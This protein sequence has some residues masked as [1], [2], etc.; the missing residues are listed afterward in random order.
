MVGVDMRHRDYEE[1][2][3]S[4]QLAQTSDHQLAVGDV[5]QHVRAEHDLASRKLVEPL[6]ELGQRQITDEV[7]AFLLL[8]VDVHLPYAPCPQRAEDVVI[9]VRLLNSAE[10]LGGRSDVQYPRTRVERNAREER[11]Q[12]AR[13]LPEHGRT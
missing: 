10:V 7:D 8:D 12:P 11:F 4:G 3:R 9:D 2:A 5:L 1:A 13:L 6:P